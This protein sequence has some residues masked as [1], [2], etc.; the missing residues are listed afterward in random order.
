MR[1]F[2][3]D[4]KAA[5]NKVAAATKAAAEAV[6][7]EVKKVAAEAKRVAEEAARLIEDEA[8]KVAAEAEKAAAAAKR[9]AEEAVRATKRAAEEA[10]KAL[11][12]AAKEVARLAA[13]AAEE[14]A[15]ALKKLG[16]EACLQAC[17][18]VV[19]GSI[20]TVDALLPTTG[21]NVCAF[22]RKVSEFGNSFKDFVQ[23]PAADNLCITLVAANPLTKGL[24]LLTSLGKSAFTAV[25]TGCE[26]C[27]V[28][29]DADDEC[30]K[31]VLSE[32]KNAPY[33]ACKFCG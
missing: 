15:R 25:T 8:K 10:A 20:Q 7:N 17:N 11:E 29:D 31:T 14:T 22:S 27:P 23:N 32:N 5:A 6:A 12:D 16:K 30:A 2:F 19:G 9:A 18:C 26:N 28:V 3:D 21:K 24:G 4:T 33:K 13:V 1:G